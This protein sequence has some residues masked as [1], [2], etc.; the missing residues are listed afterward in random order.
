MASFYYGEK[1]SLPLL[2]VTICI[3]GDHTNR[4]PKE[5]YLFA[6]FIFRSNYGLLAEQVGL[7][8]TILIVLVGTRFR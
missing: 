3:Q 4:K 8:G 7:R 6:P 2:L 5:R 1:V